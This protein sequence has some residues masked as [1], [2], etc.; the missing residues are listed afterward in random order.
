MHIRHKPTAAM[1]GSVC[2]AQLTSDF[3]PALRCGTR[4]IADDQLPE[5][6][7]E[8]VLFTQGGGSLC[9]GAEPI[10]QIVGLADRSSAFLNSAN[11]TSAFSS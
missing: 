3:I 8:L 2:D 5:F 1:C 6:R 10:A 4:G 7:A 11:C 9:V